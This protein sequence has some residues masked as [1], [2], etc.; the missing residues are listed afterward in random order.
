M[1]E[2]NGIKNEDALVEKARCDPDAF[3]VLYQYYLDPLYRYLLQRVHHVHDAEDLTTRVFM[4]VLEGLTANRYQKGGCF[5]AW[6]F[7]I[8]RRRVADYYREHTCVPLDDPPNPAPDVFTN[9]EKEEDIQQ[10]THLLTQLGEQQQ[11]LLRLRFSANLSFA[12]I[13]VLEGRTEA[14]VKMA[15]YRIL[16]YLREHWE[17]DDE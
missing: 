15:V 9:I 12:E 3:A 14:A 5:A 13:G 11:E 16:D 10:L 6:L 8:A 7:T 4:Q 17:E 2:K 1:N